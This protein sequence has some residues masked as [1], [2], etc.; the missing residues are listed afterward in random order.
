MGYQRPGWSDDLP[1]VLVL[2]NVGDHPVH[3]DAERFSGFDHLA[4]SLVS[5]DV[6]DLR[7]GLTLEPLGFAWLHATPR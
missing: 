6:H 7:D 1:R 3:I 2:A 4:K 5:G